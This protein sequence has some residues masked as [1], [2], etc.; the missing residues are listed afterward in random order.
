MFRSSSPTLRPRPQCADR[1]TRWS[2]DKPGSSFRSL[3]CCKEA[4]QLLVEAD[5]QPGRVP[6]R[7][8]PEAVDPHVIKVCVNSDLSRS[9]LFW[10]NTTPAFSWT[11]SS[12]RSCSRSL[13]PP[14]TLGQF[15][16]LFSSKNWF[17]HLPPLLLL[18]LL[19]SWCPGSTSPASTLRWR[20]C[21]SGYRGNAR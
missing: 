12:T 2:W 19:P 15:S 17:L 8:E 14:L 7:S 20:C 3:F 18:H 10:T 6:L 9:R 4:V 1:P 16:L 5:P 13:A 11:R 21:G